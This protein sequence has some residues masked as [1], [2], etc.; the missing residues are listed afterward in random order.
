MAPAVV[1]ELRDK[2]HQWGNPY[3]E[4]VPKPILERGEA[5]LVVGGCISTSNG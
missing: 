3:V 5:A 1:Y 2:F 4:V